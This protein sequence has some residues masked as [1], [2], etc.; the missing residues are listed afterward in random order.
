MISRRSDFNKIGSF[1]RARLQLSRF[2]V[3]ARRREGWIFLNRRLR[4]I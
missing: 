3:G 1:L 2:G 4:K